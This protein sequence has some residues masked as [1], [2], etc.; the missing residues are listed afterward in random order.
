MVMQ[1]FTLPN[2]TTQIN[3]GM[4]NDLDQQNLGHYC[5]WMKKY[6]LRR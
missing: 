3:H 4:N 1:N 5:L 2:I 6:Y